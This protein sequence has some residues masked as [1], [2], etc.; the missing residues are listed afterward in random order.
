MNFTIIIHYRPPRSCFCDCAGS[1][2]SWLIKQALEGR[3]WAWV[4]SQRSK[5]NFG[6]N[7]ASLDHSLKFNCQLYHRIR[8]KLGI[9]TGRVSSKLEESLKEY[10][11]ILSQNGY[12]KFWLNLNENNDNSKPRTWGFVFATD[13]MLTKL[14][15]YGNT[16]LLIQ[17]LTL[18]KVTKS[19]REYSF[20]QSSY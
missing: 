18:E 12:V 11:D 13:Y 5:V 20:T 19:L 16:I 4:N 8:Q 15:Q 10:Q 2:R 9:F 3:D 17:R 6:T 14:Q 1:V 7:I